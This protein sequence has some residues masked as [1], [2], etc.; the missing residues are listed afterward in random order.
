MEL[1]LGDDLFSSKQR[2]RALEDM[3]RWNPD[4]VVLEPPCFPWCSL[5]N[6]NDPKHVAEL[7]AQHYPLWKFVSK[8]WDKQCKGSRLALSEQPETAQSL[9]LDIMEDRKNLSRV[10]VSQCAYGLQDPVSLRPYHKSISID[11]NDDLFASHLEKTKRPCR[12]SRE[13]H[14]TIQGT[15]RTPHGSQR[16]SELA[17]RWTPDFCRWILDAAHATLREKSRQVTYCAL[18]TEVEEDIWDVFETEFFEVLAIE[19][20]TAFEEEVRK[21]FSQ[22]SKE[23][24]ARRGDV[25]GISAR[26]GYISFDGPGLLVNR[27]TRNLFAKLHGNLCHPSNQRLARMLSVAGFASDIVEAAKHLRCQICERIAAP[28]ANPKVNE[29]RPTCVNQLVG[30]DSFVCSPASKYAVSGSVASVNL[31][32]E[33]IPISRRTR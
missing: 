21:R 20:N 33:F 26:Y 11:V 27:P 3:D 6:M 19:E 29:K 23:E 5:Q 22:L 13:E 12:W 25:S 9:K 24:A 31:K 28:A 7:R 8:V 2:A 10:K 15:V 32:D 14:E 17:A 30:S 1:L 18:H 4:L 16:R